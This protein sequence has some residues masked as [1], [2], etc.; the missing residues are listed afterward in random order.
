MA[1]AEG[2]ALV[3]RGADVLLGFRAPIVESRDTEWRDTESRDTESR[4]TESRFVARAC[5]WTPPDGRRAAMAMMADAR[6]A[7]PGAT[8]RGRR[9]SELGCS[10]VG[11]SEIGFAEIRRT[12]R[13]SWCTSV[14]CDTAGNESAIGVRPGGAP[15]IMQGAN[16]ELT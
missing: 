12:D 8:R 5:A 9:R 14:I 13:R 10:E 3:E 7:I 16:R 15:L 6:T 4:D 1:L 2:V 11:R